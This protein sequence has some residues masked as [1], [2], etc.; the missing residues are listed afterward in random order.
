MQS[1]NYSDWL[2]NGSH[3]KTCADLGYNAGYQICKSY[4]DHANDKRKAIQEI[5]SLDYDNVQAVES[6]LIQSQ[7]FK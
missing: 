6:F 3:A 4:F 1:N 5:I 7:Y 2:Y